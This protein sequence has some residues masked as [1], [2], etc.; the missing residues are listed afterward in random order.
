MKQKFEESLPDYEQ[1]KNM[2]CIVIG[3]SESSKKPSQSKKMQKDYYNKPKVIGKSHILND[4]SFEPNI[5]KILR[6][7]YYQYSHEF[8]NICSTVLNQK[9]KIINKNIYKFCVSGFSNNN[10]MMGSIILITDQNRP[11]FFAQ[12]LEHIKRKAKSKKDPF[13]L[14]NTFTYVYPK[15]FNDLEK[16]FKLLSIHDDEIIENKKDQLTRIIIVT[17]IQSTNH[18]AFNI[19]IQRILEYNRREFPKYNYILIF[20]VAYDPKTLFDK[21]N[22][23]LLSK[24]ILFSITNTPSNYLYHEILYNFIYKMNT[25]FYIPKSHSL[26]EV[27]KSIELHQ[28]S[29]ESFKHY[30]NLI[31][32]QFFFMHQWN[33]DEYLIFMEEL[34]ENKIKQSLNIEKNNENNESV[35]KK[36][37]K[38][39]SE[40]D[41]ETLID[42]K[43]REIFEK[44]LKEIYTPELKEL[45]ETNN[46]LS[47]DISTEVEKLLKN[48]KDKMNTWKI[49]KK[50]Y[51]LFE[52][53]ITTYLKDSKDHK[54]SVYYFLYKFLQYDSSSNF[55]EIIKKRAKAINKI[56]NKLEDAIEPYKKYFYP[57]YK[58]TLEEIEP[59]LNNKDKEALK[60]VTQDL[61]TFIEKLDKPKIENIGAISDN[62]NIWVKE[63]FKIEFFRK[64]NE[65][66]HEQV[67]ENCKRKYANVY[68]R[69]LDYKYLIEPPLMNTF[70][71]DL[72]NYAVIVKGKKEK[73]LTNFEIKQE[74]FEFK[75]A[76]RAYFKC[77]MNLSSTFKLNH[78]FYDFLIEFNIN[79]INDKNKEL[80]EKYKKIFLV[81]CYW[82]NLVG[83]FQKKKG[84][85][86][87]F[88]KNYYEK[89][90]YI[91]NKDNH[92]DNYFIHK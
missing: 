1:Y 9:Y 59:L 38:K 16:L 81:L 4:T 55:E 83:V 42:N 13:D 35:E 77:L 74:D 31:L 29:I 73:A 47:S 68:H 44:K 32:F 72:F 67:R 2:S 15:N 92:K 51:E 90:K 40:T 14:E 75:N 60:T 43:R 28:I 89:V 63:L 5:I 54:D 64:I 19:F 57:N 22:V 8:S 76:L 7:L 27:L 46:I 66:D 85:K 61:K 18:V 25:G 62:F 80:V 41:I 82:F 86:Q 53:F 37:K 23:S 20:D 87:I 65:S 56:I 11:D 33:D 17:D 69:Y 26:K 91:N 71:V 10:G 48:Y 52:G 79:T 34:D 78:F 45:N 24:I 6:A 39:K 21:I 84:K 36:S 12:L 49:F 30:F 50:F 3:P 88:V 70:L 58:K